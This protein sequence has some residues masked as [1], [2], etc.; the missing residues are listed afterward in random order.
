M[1]IR[2][3]LKTDFYNLWFDRS[4]NRTRSTV[5]A[6]SLRLEVDDLF[7]LQKN[8][9]RVVWFKKDPCPVRPDIV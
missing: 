1:S 6:K 8:T 2:K 5:S 9:N 4:G 7:Y 3:A